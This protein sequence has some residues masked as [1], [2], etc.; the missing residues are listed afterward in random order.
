MSEHGG[1]RKGSGRKPGKTK[2]KQAISFD[3]KK[4]AALKKKAKAMGVPVS[5][6]L[7]QCIET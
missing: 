3:A 6:L 1:A 4:W 7:E 5:R 2:V